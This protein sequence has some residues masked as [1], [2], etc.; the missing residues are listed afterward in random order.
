MLQPDQCTDTE[1]V[2]LHYTGSFHRIHTGV[3]HEN[4]IN[5]WKIVPLAGGSAKWS[6]KI[7]FFNKIGLASVAAGA[8]LNLLPIWVRVRKKCSF[9]I[10]KQPNRAN[11]KFL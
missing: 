10:K 4:W 6:R 5:K 3:R 8:V 7:N 2:F 11:P 1:L 9:S